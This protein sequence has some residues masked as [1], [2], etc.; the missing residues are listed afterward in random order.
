MIR[1]P[2]VA[3]ALA[4]AAALTLGGCTATDQL[5]SD[6][7]TGDGAGSRDDRVTEFPVGER[8]DPI[9]FRAPDA[10]GAEVTAEQF[11]GKVLVVN[12]WYAACGPCR[13]EAKDLREVSAATTDTA[14][15]LGVDTSDSA[16]TVTSFVDAY[17]IPY[18][19][20]LDVEDNAVQL[21][22]AARTAPNA[23]PSTLVLDPE[24]R[25]SARIL[26]PVD[27]S[28]LTTLIATAAAT[29]QG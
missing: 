4:L 22:F 9:S 18:A 26:G 10:S 20:V 5:A 3:A 7:H 29:P 12:F 28:T 14:T 8:G 6:F 19:N 2:L 25:V 15:F 17:D 27:P 23:T 21:A 16:D 24:G 13:L 1:R 11:R